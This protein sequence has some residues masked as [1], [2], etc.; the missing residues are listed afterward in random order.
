[1]LPGLRSSAVSSQSRCAITTCPIRSSSSSTIVGVA[2]LASS[3]TRSL[4]SRSWWG[5]RR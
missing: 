4:K 5:Q 1:M 3:L 2:F